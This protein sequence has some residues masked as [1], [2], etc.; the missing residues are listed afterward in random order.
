MCFVRCRLR[1]LIEDRRS[2][3]EIE[4][5]DIEKKKKLSIAEHRGS[6]VH[7]P[8]LARGI[9]GAAF[10]L[11]MS[12]KKEGVVIPERSGHRAFVI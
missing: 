11:Q 6:S 12:P 4:N 8:V 2:Y 5:M 7:V 10:H 3:D 1:P 9:F